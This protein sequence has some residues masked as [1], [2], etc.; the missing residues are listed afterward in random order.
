[1]MP[2]SGIWH[3]VEPEV[4]AAREEMLL[5]LQHLQPEG[6][7]PELEVFI[8]AG[9]TAA[10]SQSAS[11]GDS[12]RQEFETARDDGFSLR[13]RCRSNINLIPRFPFSIDDLVLMLSLISLPMGLL[14]L[15]VW[16]PEGP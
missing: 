3:G 5:H 6:I 4:L 7:R 2:G 8:E 13:E 14:F 9:E 15:M 16:G 10:V 12:I 1:M 11:V